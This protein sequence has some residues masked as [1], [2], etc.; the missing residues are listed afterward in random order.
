[1]TAT[2]TARPRP[3]KAPSTPVPLIYRLEGGAIA[4][5]A[6]VM[7][8]LLG[9]AWWWLLVFFLAFD[10]SA[11]GYAAG[12]RAGAIG[13]NLVHNYFAPGLLAAAY[14]VLLLA[15]TMFWP[16]AF[17]AGCWF[18]HVGLDRALGYGPR[19]LD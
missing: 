9:F 7:F 19:P 18:F 12:N 4:A 1:M 15:G 6:L 5:V 10:L 17:V 3:V 8:I 14:V 16:L 13:Y 2:A 11:I